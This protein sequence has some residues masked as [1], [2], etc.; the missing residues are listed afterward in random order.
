[1]FLNHE[2]GG[3]GP[4]RMD[5]AICYVVLSIMAVITF[6]VLMLEVFGHGHIH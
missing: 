3:K 6:S 1:M 5:E 2:P 4:L